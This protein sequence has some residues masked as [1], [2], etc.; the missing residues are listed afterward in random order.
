MA[1]VF[2][3]YCRRDKPRVAPLVAAIEAMGW[4]VWWDPAMAAGEEFDGQINA[5]LQLATAVLVIW[6][7]DSVESR[8]VRGEAR[9][10]AERGVM[11]PARFDGATLPIDLRAFHTIDL[12]GLSQGARSSQVQELLH[13]LGTV[14]TRSS[15]SRPMT[16]LPGSG[17]PSVATGP[18]RGAIHA[19]RLSGEPE[20]TPEALKPAARI[21]RG[22][23]MLALALAL[24]LIA[25]ALGWLFRGDVL[26]PHQVSQSVAADAAPTQVKLD[27]R[28][29][30]VL[31]LVNASNDADQQFFSDGLSEN[32]IDSLSR[33]DGLKV[34]G[35]ISAFQFRHSK[36][37]SAT[38]GRKLGVAYLLNG[39][40]QRD[41]GVVR[42][43]ASLT[44]AADGS[45]LWSEHYDRPYKDLF[46]LQ[47]EIAQAVA[48]ALRVKL[49][50]PV[51][52]AMQDD[53]PP[54]GNVEA[55]NAYLQGLK[56]WHD[57][58]WTNAA[59]YMAQAVQLDPRYAMA[60]AQLSGSWSTAAVFGNESPVVAAEYMRK[61][62]LAADKALQLAPA[63]GPAHAARAYLQFYN[64]D[65]QS[66][67]AECRR[68]LELAPE[69]GTVLNGCGFTLGGIGKLDE[70]IQLRNRLR[71]IE[72][73]Y[74]V[75]YFQ[76]SKLLR[77][78]GRLD[79][80]DKSLRMAE[81]LSKPDPYMQLDA[82]L[83]R[84]DANAAMSIAT[85]VPDDR[86]LY[87]ALAAQ[88]GLDRAAA[89]AALE[90]IL[91]DQPAAQ[92][93]SYRIAQ[94][95]ALRRDADHAVQW[96][97]RAETQGI[98]FLL[99]DPLILRMRDD[100]RFIAFC[101]KVGLPPPSESGA[102]SIDQIRALPSSR[103]ARP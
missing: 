91:H 57:Q 63:L 71:A 16:A 32:L 38:I 9:D 23:G 11:V 102:L 89:D 5:E 14:M 30:A 86:D 24:A 67:L 41:G 4:S 43:S 20:R 77:A 12:D 51:A 33:F 69:D 94:V 53:R 84:G 85:Q 55:Y 46:T 70:A 88:I 80:A 90:N 81:G 54:S 49:L 8:W 92:S 25:L 93:R 83:L 73:L 42:I 52:A 103:Q 56:Y 74:H 28:S 66:A 27:D 17:L 3:S 7:P 36:D 100:P 29:I 6:T 78:T 98:L 58:D 87:L 40:V 45:T 13:A 22:K 18:D 19:L 99:T 65:Y 50:S 75:N 34:I 44:K 68:A 35:R 96:L 76:Y 39:S 47:D 31:P 95:Y 2:V 21:S 59:G 26:P 97:E 10:A 37:D 62:R 79:E 72:P 48:D 15:T 101:K 64:F 61:S 60:W 82:A 1:D